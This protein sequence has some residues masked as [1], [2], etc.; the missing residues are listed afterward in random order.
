MDVYIDASLGH[1]RELSS[2]GSGSLP[3]HLLTHKKRA[4]FRKRWR[5][6]IAAGIHSSDM[7][8][9][10]VRN[11]LVPIDFSK[12]S[13]QAIETAKRLAQRF[14]AT[15]HL[16]HVHQFDYPAGVMPPAA[17]PF[18][19]FSVVSYDEDAEKRLFRQLRDLARKN[20]LLDSGACHIQTGAPV[21]EKKLAHKKCALNH[22]Y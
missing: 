6:T 7:K 9:Q 19:P 10:N 18:I 20:D 14:G 5:A 12:M 2:D 15:V 3:S 1:Y 11:I 4:P 16:A 21:D 22:N 17:P 8:T 13:I